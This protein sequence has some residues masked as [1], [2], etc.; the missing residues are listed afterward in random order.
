LAHEKHR[1][2]YVKEGDRVTGPF[3]TAAVVQDLLL[4]RLGASTLLSQDQSQWSPASALEEFCEA[5]R[6]AR[7][8]QQRWKAV[9][10]WAE[11]RHGPDRRAHPHRAGGRR[12]GRDRRRKGDSSRR[13]AARRAPPSESASRR[14]WRVVAGLLLAIA[15][16]ILVAF[17]L[18]PGTA[19][20][21]KLLR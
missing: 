2:W 18:G 8:E 15:V 12:T 7:A 5:I 1:L 14:P 10:R 11:Q 17:A 19:P 3:P 13:A 6:S 4:G 20:E 9:R 21:I 16:L